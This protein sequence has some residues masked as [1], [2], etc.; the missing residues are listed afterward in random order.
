[1]DVPTAD[2]EQICRL[3][4]SISPDSEIVLN[5]SFSFLG[6]KEVFLNSF[7][8]LCELTN[9]DKTGYVWKIRKR[10]PLVVAIFWD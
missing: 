1:M 6:V 10:K 4:T 7:Y 5:T 2:C 9:N 3:H 8:Y